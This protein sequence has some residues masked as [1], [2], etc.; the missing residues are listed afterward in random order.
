MYLNIQ[1]TS[2]TSGFS[3][4]WIF[5]S[6]L[7]S[8]NTPIKFPSS[9]SHFVL[10]RCSGRHLWDV[11]KLFFIYLFFFTNIAPVPHKFLN[12]LGPIGTLCSFLFYLLSSSYRIIKPES[13]KKEEKIY[14][15][16]NSRR[17]PVPE[18]GEA[19]LTIY[20]QHVPMCTDG[21]VLDDNTPRDFTKFDH[22][23]I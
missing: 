21:S 8:V 11:F 1:M 17:E 5:M 20:T 14:N 4:G 9:S 23:L 6:Y 3:Q 16:R 13:L 15:C 19:A 22:R 2:E 7:C 12:I 18:W 10:S